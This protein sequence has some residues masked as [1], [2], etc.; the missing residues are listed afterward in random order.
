MRD[1]HIITRVND[2]MRNQN[3]ISKMLLCSHLNQT[4]KIFQSIAIGNEELTS[5]ML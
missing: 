4:F 2:Y 1:G 5:F 3:S